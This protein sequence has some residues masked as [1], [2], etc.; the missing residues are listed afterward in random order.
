M[1]QCGN[2]SFYLL[3]NQLIDDFV[4][5]VHK[6]PEDCVVAVL[7][8]KRKL[9][10]SADRARRFLSVTKRPQGFSLASS[11]KAPVSTMGN[12]RRSNKCI[13]D[14]TDSLLLWPKCVQIEFSRFHSDKV[15][16]KVIFMAGVDETRENYC[17]H[18]KNWIYDRKLIANA[19]WLDFVLRNESCTEPCSDATERRNFT[20]RTSFVGW[21]AL[22]SGSRI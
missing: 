8:V 3:K 14:G 4:S 10:S 12:L 18:H 13:T 2:L 7:P 6:H 17:Y 22:I 1:I 20:T 9:I 15:A 5:G 11:K 16:S 19:N 21:E